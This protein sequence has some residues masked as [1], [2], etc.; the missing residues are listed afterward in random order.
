M[1][2]QDQERRQKS[3]SS[4]KNKKS[5]ARQYADSFLVALAIA[6][7]I[8]AVVIYPF[9]IPTGSM[10]DTL[11]VG[12]FLLANKFVY[13][14]RSPDWIGIPYTKIGFK[15]P[16]FRTPGFRKPQKGDVVIFKYPRDITL[17]YI[18][19]CV[20]A[21]GDTI[22][23][24]NKHLFVNGR[25]FPNAPKSKF[26]HDLVYPADFEEYTI[27]PPGVGNRDNYG[28]VRIPA[29]GDTFHFTES[30]RSLWFERL[31]IA[32]YEGNRILAR[33]GGENIPLTVDN[34]NQWPSAVQKLAPK[35]FLINGRP[36]DGMVYTVKNRHYFM[37]GDNRD[38]SL[39]SRYW[40][41]LPE[42]LVVGEALVIYWS[43]DSDVPL[44]RLFKK[45]R[46][47]RLLNLIR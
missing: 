3:D 21:S 44:Y 37:M 41:Y 31:Q 18:K 14:I 28:P 7:V 2:H 1:I 35:D 33:I 24:R 27:Y 30:N 47:E 36:L 42:R 19:R 16:F 4:V 10:E 39:D 9:R 13:G 26:I 6:L 8:R 11:L 5:G 25:A 40:G 12:D 29:P 17:N 20:G 22:L 38:N 34:Q 43:W 23:V 32:L 46:W 45:I 15:I